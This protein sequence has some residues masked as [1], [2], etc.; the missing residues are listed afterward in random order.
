[1]GKLNTHTIIPVVLQYWDRPKNNYWEVMAI[2]QGQF[3][4]EFIP[5]KEL[6][7]KLPVALALENVLIKHKA[8][9]LDRLEYGK[10]PEILQSCYRV[11]SVTGTCVI[12]KDSS[13]ERNLIKLLGFPWEPYMEALITKYH[14]EDVIRIHPSKRILIEVKPEFITRIIKVANGLYANYYSNGQMNSQA[15]FKNGKLIRAYKEYERNGKLSLVKYYEDTTAI[16]RR[17]K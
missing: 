15:R 2:Y 12:G 11:Q 4:M 8:T 6:S 5:K 13:E 3:Y 14:L 1:M 17:R 10:L 9:V 7:K 16:K